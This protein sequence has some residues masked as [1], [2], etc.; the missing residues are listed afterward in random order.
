[1]IIIIFSRPDAFNFQSGPNFTKDVQGP[2]LVT[3][4]LEAADIKALDQ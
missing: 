3:P 4:S 1:M 2:N